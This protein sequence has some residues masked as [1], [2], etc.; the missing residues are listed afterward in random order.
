MIEILS[1][2]HLFRPGCE[3]FPSCASIHLHLSRGSI[4]QWC[5]WVC[6]TLQK[7]SGQ[8][9][10]CSWQLTVVTDPMSMM[11]HSGSSFY[12]MPSETQ[13]LKRWHEQ[14]ILE[15][16]M[17]YL[18]GTAYH[19]C[20]TPPPPFSLSLLLPSRAHSFSGFLIDFL[21]FHIP[22]SAQLFLGLFHSLTFRGPAC[23]LHIHTSG[24]FTCRGWR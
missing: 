14:T 23:S 3:I 19:L 20:F 9:L 18:C 4:L 10:P 24:V 5:C 16:N 21:L 1:F 17:L 6:S 7:T 22:G 12:R 13:S 11:V 8:T 2:L 15:W